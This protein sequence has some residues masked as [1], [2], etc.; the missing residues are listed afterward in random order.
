MT[1]T[2][3][4]PTT[5]PPKRLRLGVRLAAVFATVAV[6]AA[7]CG[8]SAAVV[9][10]NGT[11]QNIRAGAVKKYG[12]ASEQKIKVL[13]EGKRGGPVLL[14]VVG[15]GYHGLNASIT[16]EIA[17]EMP[18]KWRVLQMTYTP[19]TVDS[20][21]AQTDKGFAWVVKNTDWASWGDISNIRI[22]GESAGGQTAVRGAL[23]QKAFKTNKVY[24]LAGTT[25]LDEWHR[26]W[27][28][29]PIGIDDT[30]E[31]VTGCT[32]P[33]W[34]SCETVRDASPRSHFRSGPKVT[35]V[36]GKQDGMVPVS[37]SRLAYERYPGPSSLVE[38][39]GNHFD[40]TFVKNLAKKIT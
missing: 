26:Y 18:S 40:A 32:N 7:G 27:R 13:Q 22:A 3:D 20:V 21:E 35:F 17:K 39:Q 30:I 16:P 5:L 19:G 37:V 14:S 34:R 33:I 12:N 11:P 10:A 9:P 38:V 1:N 29:N 24:S 31:M 28:G 6:F 23:E 25:E 15:G 4:S 2:R 36:H 8:C